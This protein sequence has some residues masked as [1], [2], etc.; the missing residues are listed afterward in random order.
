MEGG[1]WWGERGE[2]GTLKQFPAIY[3]AGRNLESDDM[4][5]RAPNMSVRAIA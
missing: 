5:L 4:T 1:E 3:L 2:D